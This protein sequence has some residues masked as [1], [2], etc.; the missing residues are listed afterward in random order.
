MKLAPN[1][2]RFTTCYADFETIPMAGFVLV[3]DDSVSM[4]DA[5]IPQAVTQDLVPFLGTIGKQIGHVKNVFITH[6]HPDHVGGLAL[7]KAANPNTQV[8]CSAQ[9]VAWVEDQETMWQDLFLR[10][11]ELELNDEAHNYVVNTLGGSP[12]S[13]D[14]TLGAGDVVDL[15][16]LEI[17]VL[18]A[19]GH[20]PGHL[21]FLEKRNGLLFTGD[22]VQGNGIGFVNSNTALPPLYEDLELYVASLE[23][24]IEVE[25]RAVLSAHHEPQIGERGIE[26]LRVSIDTALQARETVAQT[27]KKAT[28]P[29]TVAEVGAAIKASMEDRNAVHY[30]G[31]LQFLAVAEASL[32][33]LSEQ[34]E[35]TAD[36]DNH[37]SIAT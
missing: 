32:R 5:L 21:A 19:P 28:S 20:S 16:G 23:H 7:I 24:M 3:G 15:G 35:A 9:E 11:P 13:V 33:S 4:I 18:D 8:L 10:Y 29:L 31:E 14:S 34:A 27:L 17:L 30:R 36:Q 1:V 22:S 2:Y 37:W 12:T 26:F 6:G 25:P